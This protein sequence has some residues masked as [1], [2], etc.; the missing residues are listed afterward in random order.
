MGAFRRSRGISGL[1]AFAALLAGCG[2]SHAAMPLPAVPANELAVRSQTSS[3]YQTLYD[4]QGYPDGAYPEAGLVAIG[5]TLYGTAYSG[6]STTGSQCGFGCGTVFK[7]SDSGSEH[8]LYRFKGGSDGASPASG[9]AELGGVLYGTTTFGGTGCA[10]SG[11]CGTVFKVSLSGAEKVIYSF[12]GIAKKDGAN[13]ELNETLLA[14]K[15]A[16]YGS[17]YQGGA[18][19]GTVY[20]ITPSGKETVLHRFGMK[21]TDGTFPTGNLIAYKGV[22][23]GTASSGGTPDR[24]VAFAI[25]P[26]GKERILYAFEGGSDGAG[27]DALVAVG[28]VLY[29]TTTYGGGSGCYNSGCG[30]FFSLTTSGK[31]KVLYRFQNGSD[32]AYP[33]TGGLVT[34]AQQKDMLYGTSAQGGCGY[35]KICG[36][37]FAIS[38]SG[39]ESILYNFPTH[40]GGFEPLAPLVSAAGTLYG[41][42][43]LGGISDCKESGS[44]NLGCGTVFRIVP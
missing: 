26:S 2:G 38:T 21:Q 44:S 16:L 19:Y 39:K 1:L 40:P 34:V 28:G 9:L 14:Y 3:G 20:E 29:G 10:S 22:F 15:G 25:T 42:T 18:K 4:F 27:P 7:V 12:K 36:T 35:V 41:T 33:T 5:G 17:T 31:E 32:A 6:G 23:Y 37:V 30:T 8:V 13:P 11:G 43:N 24:G